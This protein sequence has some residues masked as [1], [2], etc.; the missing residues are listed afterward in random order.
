MVVNTPGD[1]LLFDSSHECIGS[2]WMSCILGF[3][4]FAQSEQWSSAQ[5]LHF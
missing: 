4:W 2:Q 3:A 1:S 5:V